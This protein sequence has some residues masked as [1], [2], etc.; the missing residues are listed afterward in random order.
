MS[1]ITWHGWTTHANADVYEELLA[2]DIL[3]EIAA[4]RVPGYHGIELL[5]REH[6][7]DMNFI[8]MTTFESEDDVRAFVGD[9][10]RA[11]GREGVAS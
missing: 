11:V 7:S 9:D 10:S 6:D 4:K 3:V 5:R 1:R 8:T 2:T